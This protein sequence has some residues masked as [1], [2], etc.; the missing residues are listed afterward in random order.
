MEALHDGGLEAL[1]RQLRRQLQDGAERVSLTAPAARLLLD[2]LGRLSQS[3][4][5]L[6]RQNR[7]LRRRLQA[8]TG[9]ATID[10]T[11]DDGPEAPAADAVP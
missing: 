10:E 4:D 3:S 8:A 9:E 2:E 1:R 11:A 5:R 7:R 6:R